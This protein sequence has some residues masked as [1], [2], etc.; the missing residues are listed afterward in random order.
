MVLTKRR[1]SEKLKDGDEIIGLA[2]E[3]QFTDRWIKITFLIRKEIK[4]P[5]TAIPH[6]ILCSLIGKKIGV[7]NVD[8]DF[9]VR[10]IQSG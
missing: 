5:S 1:K 4:L 10:E 6:K 3:V 9:F 8:G 2:E 7:I